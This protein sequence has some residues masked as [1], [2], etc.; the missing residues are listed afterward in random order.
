[1]NHV[2][3]IILRAWKTAL[4]ETNGRGLTGKERQNPDFKSKTPDACLLAMYLA[5]KIKEPA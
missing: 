4:P 3:K 5:D 1:M 2:I